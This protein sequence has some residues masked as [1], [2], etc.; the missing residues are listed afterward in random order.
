[1]REMGTPSPFLNGLYAGGRQ[2]GEAND[3]GSNPNEGFS[4]RRASY[5]E[6]GKQGL[7]S[8]VGNA[9]ETLLIAWLGFGS[10]TL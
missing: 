9:G 7:S 1:V 2:M 5:Y 3:E 4:F 8:K 10:G 6:G